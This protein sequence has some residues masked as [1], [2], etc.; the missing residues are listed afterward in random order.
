MAR[1]VTRGII[2]FASTKQEY[3][4][5]I[6]TR[7]AAEPE[8]THDDQIRA[9]RTNLLGLLTFNERR[10]PPRAPDRWVADRAWNMLVP[11]HHQREVRY[12]IRVDD[13]L[14]RVPKRPRL[15]GALKH[16]LFPE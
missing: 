14:Q 16:S 10:Q 13:R 12:C 4:P 11:G 9:S 1:E 2:H 6:L 7:I 5:G 8:R 15:A 3:L